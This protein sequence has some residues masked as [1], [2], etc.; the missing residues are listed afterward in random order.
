MQG[1]LTA[2]PRGA[3]PLPLGR[4]RVAR[5][6]PLRVLGAMRAR[7]CRPGA[8]IPAFPGPEA[9]LTPRQRGWGGGDGP[10]SP[11]QEGRGHFLRWGGGDRTCWPRA[12][13]AFTSRRIF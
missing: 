5:A 3:G 2:G 1:N 9:W 6:A 12:G 11:E 10:R 8:P 13:V 7:C 4:D